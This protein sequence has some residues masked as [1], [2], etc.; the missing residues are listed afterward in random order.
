M[1]IPFSKYHGAG[2]DFIIID[3]RSLNIEL[4]ELK[5]FNLCHRRFGVGADGLMLL[6]KS[7]TLDFSMKYFNSDGKEGTMCGN[8]GRCIVA[9]AKDK[10]IEKKHYQ[11]STIDGQ[12]EAF[13]EIDLINLKM[14]DVSQ[15]T[16]FDN[17]WFLDTGSPHL[18]ELVSGL[19]ELDLND[20]GKKRRFD[21]RFQPGGT[22]ANFIELEQNK[23]K[24]R[25]YERGVEAETLACGT[26]AVASAIVAH[27]INSQF[28]KFEIEALGG[29]LEVSFDFENDVYTNIWLKG[30]AVKSFEGFFEL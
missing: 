20:I 21:P 25:T 12:H 19:K 8:G 10:G 3:Q 22:N 1:Q 29:N 2:N 11:F 28:K 23:I 9:F 4:S 15:V 13:L 27:Q 14:N 18:V 5:I 7:E 17:D 24:I 26:G 30:S 16:R 6:E